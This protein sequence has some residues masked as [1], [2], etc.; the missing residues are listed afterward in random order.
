MAAGVPV[1]SSPFGIAT[2]P[3]LVEQ[4]ET[5]LTID[6]VDAI[7]RAGPKADRAK[8]YIDQNHGIDAWVAAWRNLLSL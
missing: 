1:V 5:E 4:V 2:D 7:L 6:W 8:S 3:Q